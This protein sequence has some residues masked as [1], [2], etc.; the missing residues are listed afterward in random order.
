MKHFMGLIV[1]IVFLF[2]FQLNAF[3]GDAYK[4][5]VVDL[6]KLQRDIKPDQIVDGTE[7]PPEKGVKFSVIVAVMLIPVPPAPVGAFGDIYL[8]PGLSE[9]V[10]FKVWLLSFEPDQLLSGRGEH[11]PGGIIF[12]M[13][14]P[15]PKIVIDPRS[16]MKGR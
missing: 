11:L 6:Q 15:D 2:G 9:S 13:A 3:S 4:I 5:G 12:G 16:R 14:N 10:R 8:S 7:M 1:G